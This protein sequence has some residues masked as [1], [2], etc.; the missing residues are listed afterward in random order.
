MVKWP[1]LNEIPFRRYYGSVDSTPLFL[2]LAGS[3]YRRTGDL[4]F[5]RSIWPNIELALTWIDRY[6][7]SDGD[8]FVEYYR[9]SDNG[10]VQQGWKDSTDSVFH[11][12]GTLVHGPVALCEVQ[13]YVYA[14][15]I[16]S[17]RN[18]RGARSAGNRQAFD[19]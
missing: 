18:R 13:A 10:L 11:A 8:G 12:D 19:P 16:E 15:K 17:R 4:E 1:A 6:G 3:Y 14:A 9:K 5:V 7:D 2:I